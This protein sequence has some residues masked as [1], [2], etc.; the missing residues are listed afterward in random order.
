[1]PGPPFSK[2]L[3]DTEIDL[4]VKHA[5]EQETIRITQANE[6]VDA[7]LIDRPRIT[8]EQGAMWIKHKEAAARQ[9]FVH[10]NEQFDL[11]QRHEA[12][13]RAMHQQ[14]AAEEAALDVPA[15]K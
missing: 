9:H 13:V 15:G 7:K 8:P 1:M 12:Q 5:V 10:V 3:S 4:L 14:H 6:S 11:T 2:K